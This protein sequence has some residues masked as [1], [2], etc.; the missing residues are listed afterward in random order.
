MGQNYQVLGKSSFEKHLARLPDGRATVH[1][2]HYNYRVIVFD[3]HKE[4]STCHCT[5]DG[6][7][8]KSMHSWPTMIKKVMLWDLYL[9]FADSSTRRMKIIV[10]TD[11]RGLMFHYPTLSYLDTEDPS[12]HQQHCADVVSKRPSISSVVVVA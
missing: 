5:T 2:Y 7:R 4:F 11:F 8:S 6:N 1:R 10:M 12:S 3:Y 9:I